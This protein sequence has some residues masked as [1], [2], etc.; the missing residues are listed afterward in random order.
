MTP[1]AVRGF[2][3]VAALAVGLLV[4]TLGAFL[5]ASRMFVAGF[6]V[7]WGTV[8]V[9]L[10]LVVLV[11]GAVELADSRWAGWSLF[12][13]WLAATV[14]FASPM[15]WGALV[16]SAGGRQMAYLFGGVVLGAAAATVP[17]WASLR[18]PRV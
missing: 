10:C 15:P 12:A 2:L 14:L 11:R 3:A 8:L 6:A 7:P 1:G 17:S 9:L 18:R 4:G 13:G 16:I 5:Q